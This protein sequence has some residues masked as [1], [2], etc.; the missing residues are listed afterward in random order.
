MKN[1]IIILFLSTL[2][3]FS[4]SGSSSPLEGK[5]KATFRN[6]DQTYLA[7]YEINKGDKPEYKGSTPKRLDDEQYEYKFLDW[8]PKI[9][10]I[11]EDTTYIATYTPSLIIRYEI[12]FKNYDGTPLGKPQKVKKGDIPVYEGPTPIKEDDDA[13]AYVFSGWSPELKEATENTSYTAK[14]TPVALDK[15]IEIL[16]EDDK[17][18]NNTYQNAETYINLNDDPSTVNN[19]IAEYLYNHK[20]DN[21]GTTSGAYIE[22][23]VG[24]TCKAPYTIELATDSEMAD[25]KYAF[26]NIN[27]KNYTLYNL[28]PDTY[29]YRI[30]DSSTNPSV[31]TIQSLT[32]TNKIRT[33]Y[34]HN[35]IDNMRDIAGLATNDGNV[36]KPGIIFRNA[37]L[38]NQS[39][40]ID[41]LFKNELHIK[42]EIDV[43]K[44]SQYQESQHPIE[45]VTFKQFGLTDAYPLMITD[46]VTKENIKNVFEFIADKNNLPISFHCTNGADRTGLLALL[47]EGTLNVKDIEIYRDYEL[48]TFYRYYQPRSEIEIDGSNY[49]FNASGYRSDTWQN[50]S[51]LKVIID[52]KTKYDP[53]AQSIAE[54]VQSFLT[55]NDIGLSTDTLNKVR[56]NLLYAQE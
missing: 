10:N 56:S 36:I 22:W 3:T 14:F 35:T 15:K 39:S 8:E 24:T 30:K 44:D 47:I 55:S 42:T 29:H 40:Y 32:I 43:R 31:S 26:S 48:T 12:T 49:N 37:N 7:S 1:K 46:S 21:R 17:E 25:I 33:I 34:N 53:T 27:S 4:C 45:G 50:G 28:V 23:K 5:C 54:A 18:F 9:T 19:E 51:F 16:T 13:Y 11:T 2:C 20:N 38:S 6:Y 52:M 41:D